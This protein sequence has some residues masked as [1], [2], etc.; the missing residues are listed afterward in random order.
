MIAAPSMIS[1][2]RPLKSKKETK[3][4]TFLCESYD[5]V[6]LKRFL[7]RSGTNQKSVRQRLK[8]SLK[9]KNIAKD[10]KSEECITDSIGLEKPGLKVIIKYCVCIIH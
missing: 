2:S 7:K 9:E 3:R 8:D 10:T 1:S 6:W 4:L 5:S